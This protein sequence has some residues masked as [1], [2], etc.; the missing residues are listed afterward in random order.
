MSFDQ[1]V[2]ISSSAE[3]VF[4]AITQNIQDWWGK[5][6]SVV[7]KLGDEFTTSFDQTF[8]KFRIIEFV[9]NQKLIWE[10]IDAR[11]IHEGYEGIEKE[12]L[13]TKVYWKIITVSENESVLEFSH[14]GLTPD[15]NC[16]EI[17]TMGWER[18]VSVSLKRYAETG[19]GMPYLS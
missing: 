10:C 17:C 7:S 13:G 12:W 19:T 9:P 8:W 4:T 18:F 2:T 6:D 14:D 15:L 3:S 5:T 16:Y 1:Q 11:H